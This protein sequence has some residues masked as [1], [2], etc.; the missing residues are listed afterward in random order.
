MTSLITITVKFKYV[1]K[2]ITEYVRSNPIFPSPVTHD[3]LRP[4]RIR[5]CVSYLN[6][7]SI[8]FK[9]TIRFSKRRVEVARK[10]VEFIERTFFIEEKRNH[11]RR[12]IEESMQYW[13]YAPCS[14]GEM[15][16][17]RPPPTD[18]SVFGKTSYVPPYLEQAKSH[19]E[20]Y[21]EIWKLYENAPNICQKQK[22]Q[23]QAFKDHLESKLKNETAT[24]HVTVTE[25]DMKTLLDI[26]YENILRDT[27]RKP[28]KRFSFKIEAAGDTILIGGYQMDK[29]TDMKNAGDLSKVLNKLLQ[30]ETAIEK[31]KA[32]QESC[33]E[34]NRNSE[35]FH[36]LLMAEIIEKV[37]LSNYTDMEGQC[38]ECS[39]FQGSSLEDILKGA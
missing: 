5:D 7:L 31:A 28:E 14:V 36:R 24:M 37:R 1:I 26:T 23:E 34:I 38:S 29:T 32:F 21:E 19:L 8:L 20:E 2:K 12:L 22:Q 18:V 27:N 17:W 35:Q 6:P 10:R 3:G 11:Y 4:V 16:S 33:K 30:D 9:D 25:Q 39:K 13:E 15:I